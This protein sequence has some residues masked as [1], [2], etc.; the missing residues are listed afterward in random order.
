M[1]HIGNPLHQD[2]QAAIQNA[3]RRLADI[4][5]PAGILSNS[6]E[7]AR[8]YIE[9]GYRFV[10]VGSDIGLVTSGT[11]RLVASFAEV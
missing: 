7:S 8:R 1:G 3:G 10:A 2:V 6:E 9:W 4:G 11:T 5:V